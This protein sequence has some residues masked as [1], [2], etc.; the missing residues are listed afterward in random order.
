MGAGNTPVL[1]S[2]DR[3]LQRAVATACTEASLSAPEVCADVQALERRLQTLAP[4]L[5]LIDLSDTPLIE[6]RRLAPVLLRFP[7]LQVV[8]L[9]PTLESDILLEAMQMG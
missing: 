3:E 6:L 1:V 9:C 4:A 7:Q 8:L 2:T 5:A